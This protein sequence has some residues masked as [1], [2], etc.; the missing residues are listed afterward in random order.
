MSVN[1]SRSH[2]TTC[3]NTCGSSARQSIVSSPAGGR[4]S[5]N[6]GV[7]SAISRCGSGNGNGRSRYTLRMV[8]AAVVI[9]MPR[10][11][12][13]NAV[14]VKARC[15]ASARTAWRNSYS[16]V[17]TLGSPLSGRSCSRVAQTSGRIRMLR[18]SRRY[19]HRARR[20]PCRAARTANSSARSPSSISISL[21]DASRRNSARA[22]RGG[23]GVARGVSVMPC[24]PWSPTRATARCDRGSCGWTAASACPRR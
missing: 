19:A 20:T 24:W 6:G 23:V 2:A 12:T 9:P 1:A 11:S 17:I 10:V 8:S 21:E 5:L 22:M 16:I 14:S 15:L 13:S 4:A 7:T 3:S 18:M